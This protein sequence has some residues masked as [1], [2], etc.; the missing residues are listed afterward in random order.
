MRGLDA[1][2][3]H[4]QEHQTAGDYLYVVGLEPH[5]VDRGVDRANSLSQ[6][7]L[8]SPTPSNSGL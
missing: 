5:D 4:G 1:V 6:L 8:G 7:H 3:Q 2:Q